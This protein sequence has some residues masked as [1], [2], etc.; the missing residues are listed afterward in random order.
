M[1][2]EKGVSTQ[3]KGQ[4]DHIYH[5]Q[6]EFFNSGV[7]MDYKFRRDQLK[8]LLAVI[9][10]NEERLTEA[11][12]ADLTKPALEAFGG[13]IG[14]VYKEIRHALKNLR[15]WMANESVPTDLAHFPSKSWIQ[16]R[17][18]GLVLIL[19]PWNYPFNL[20]FTPLIG[21][22]A[23]GNCCIIKPSEEAKHTANLVEEIIGENF[24]P[25]FLRVVQMAGKEVIPKLIEPFHFDHIFFTGSERA[26]RL[27][28]QAAAKQL[29]PVTLELGG[30]SP[31]LVLPDADYDMSA[32]RIVWGKNLNSG[33]T[34]VAPDFAI[35]PQK[36]MDH[37]LTLKKK[38]VRSFH[39]DDPLNNGQLTSIINEEHF[40][41][42]TSFLNDLEVVHGGRHDR[43]RLLIEPT[44]VKGHLGHPIMEE[45]VFGP[46]L[47][48]IGYND[49]DEVLEIIRRNP[50]PLAFYL[51]TK[52]KANQEKWL[53]AFRFGG[54]GVNT[55]LIHVA[56]TALPFGGVGSSGIGRYHGKYSFELFSV[57]QGI[58]KTGSWP[59][60]S[61][62]YPPYTDL[63]TRIAR[64]FFG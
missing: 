51:F 39:G 41:R 9:R 13:E 32:R 59:D 57:A 64:W 29:T 22:I 46:I 49:D 34:C 10:E 58:S 27:V 55:A 42:L 17:P 52:S 3:E 6:K 40:D 37:L 5:G 56:S 25:G 7:T 35:V 54:G 30:K 36:D 43:S 15:S 16:Y 50:N 26:G 60:V 61:L 28:Y 47:P 11:L 2:M 12:Y 45:E 8:K 62:R 4:L 21:A 63:K 38:H 1:Q 23:A 24:D 53:N 48:V 19:A 20:V 44:I 31:A 18:K 33:Q 14:F